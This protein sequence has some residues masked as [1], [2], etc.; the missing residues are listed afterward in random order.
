MY[1]F[2]SLYTA[3]DPTESTQDTKCTS[4]SY[5]LVCLVATAVKVMCK[6][7]GTLLDV[8]WIVMLILP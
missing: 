1:T 7:F 4:C 6:G 2:C 3:S 5:Y 8:I